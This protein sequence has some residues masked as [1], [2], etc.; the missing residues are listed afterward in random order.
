MPTS[1]SPEDPLLD[2]LKGIV[3]SA[4][5]EFLVK[6]RWFGAKARTISSVEVSDIIPFHSDG[7]RSYFILAQVKYTS[8]PV[9]TYDIPL[10]PAPR[11]QAGPVQCRDALGGLLHDYF[12]EAA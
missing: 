4:L 1:S 6:Q 7:L 11:P 9:E 10:V 2:V 3:P 5:P 12:R 8:G